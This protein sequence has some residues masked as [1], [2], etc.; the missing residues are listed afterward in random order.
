MKIEIAGNCCS[1]CHATYHAISE[2]AKEIGEGI[3]VEHIEDIREILRLGVIQMPAVIIDGKQVSA[4][5][6]YSKE[7]ARTLLLS[8]LNQR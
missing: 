6:H 8:H 2:A 5:K 3:E 1:S 7:E 4:G